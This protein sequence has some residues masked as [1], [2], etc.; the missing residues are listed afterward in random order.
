MQ[1]Q[2]DPQQ[3]YSMTDEL[4]EAAVSSAAPPP[5][6]P[7]MPQAAAYAEPLMVPQDAET[8]DIAPRGYAGFWK[9][10]F[11]LLLDAV[12]LVVIKVG[13]VLTGATSESLTIVLF[14]LYFVLFESSE[15]QA[16][17]GKMALGIK[18]VGQNG[19]RIS[20]L[21]ALGRYAAKFLSFITLCIGYI[22]VA[23]TAQ[24]QGLHDKIATTFVVNN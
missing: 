16:T 13:F 1:N 18:V 10:T 3:E 6:P 17:P 2:Q 24:K 11:A 22:M 5:P 20:F 9:R 15:K 23:F 8:V 21:R 19:L 12:I 7:A 14:M 4:P